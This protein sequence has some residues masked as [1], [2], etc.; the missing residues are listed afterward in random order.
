MKNL[1]NKNNIRSL[2]AVVCLLLVLSIVFSLCSCK[3]K[4]IEDNTSSDVTYSMDNSDA[5][6]TTSNDTSE[7]EESSS[8]D[9]TSSEESKP[10]SSGETSSVQQLPTT[11]NADGEEILGSGTKNEPYLELPNVHDDYMNVTT[12]SIPAGKSVYYGIQRVVGTILT[13]NNANAY[14][15]YDGTRYDAVGG[16][17][18]FEVINEKA[19]ASDNIIFEV[20]NKG[21]QAASFEIRFT[22]KTG[23]RENPTVIKTLGANNTVKLEEGNSTGHYYKYVAEKAG[24][25]RFYMSATADSVISVTDNSTSKNIIGN[26][27][28]K[29]GELTDP[30]QG[31][32]VVEYIELDVTKGAEI[33]I[34]VGTIP[35]KRGN[36]N[37]NQITWSGKYA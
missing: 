25:I 35:S 17:V 27:A 3:K 26:F 2:S 30:D 13:I 1:F 32:A 5:T 33:I 29:S 36:Y 11:E 4:D 37:A 19:L 31:D 7:E 24:K 28:K 22:N 9:A 14:V 6:E 34:N 20:G 16:K 23:S 10:T 8:E 21:S 12:I 15:V 18:T